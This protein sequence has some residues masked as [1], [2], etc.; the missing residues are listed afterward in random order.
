[1]GTEAI[2]YGSKWHRVKSIAEKL[3]FKPCV[4]FK[5]IAFAPIQRLGRIFQRLLRG[6]VPNKATLQF[7]QEEIPPYVEPF[8]VISLAKVNLARLPTKLKHQHQG[9]PNDAIAELRGYL[10]VG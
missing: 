1:M 6:R 3:F 2:F 4:S 7:L 9:P 10:A 8:L 5:N